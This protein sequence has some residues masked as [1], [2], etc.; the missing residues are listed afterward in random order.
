MISAICF[1]SYFFLLKEKSN[2]KVQGQPDR[3]ARLSGPT[4]PLTTRG[5]SKFGFELHLNEVKVNI[6]FYQILSLTDALSD[7]GDT[8]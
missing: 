8:I 6:R 1:S 2:K 4:P 3:S 7:G 5:I